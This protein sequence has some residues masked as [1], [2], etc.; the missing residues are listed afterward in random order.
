V[1]AGMIYKKWCVVP[2]ILLLW[3]AIVPAA[4]GIEFEHPR[5]EGFHPLDEEPDAATPLNS[6]K[7][8]ILELKSKL[9]FDQEDIDF[10]KRQITFR[11][12]DSLGF[13]MWEYHFSEL[14]EYLSSRKNFVL[15]KS[16]YNDVANA[17]RSA[18]QKKQQKSLKMQWE[19]P[20]QYPS[21]AQ[22][23]LGNEPPKLVIDG[24]LTI[25]MGFDRSTVKEGNE[26]RD[27][28]S[29]TN[30]FGFDM[31]YQFGI[32]GTVGK[33][34]NVGIRVADQEFVSENN[35]K[36]FKIEYKESTPGE[37]EDEV[38]QEVVAGWTN[39]D[40]PGTELS[41]YSGGKDGL[42][43]IK[44]KSKLGPLT[45]TTIAS[46][47]KGEAQKLNM[48]LKNGGNQSTM[49][50]SDFRRDVF[51]FLDTLY[52]NLYNKNYR[53]SKAKDPTYE[54]PPHVD[55]LEVYIK[56][57]VYQTDQIQDSLVYARASDG[58]MYYF[59]KLIPD[60]HYELYADQGY[61]RFDTT[62]NNNDLVGIYMSAR[63]GEVRKGKRGDTL[64]L[65][66]LKPRTPINSSTED[67]ERFFLMWRNV[68]HLDT[69]MLATFELS[70]WRQ[71]INEDS[72]QYCTDRKG[73]KRLI[74]ALIGLTGEDGKPLTDYDQIYDKK[75]EY[76]IVP[77][78][79]TCS[80]CNEPFNNPDLGA[81]FRDSLI[82]RVSH[83]NSSWHEYDPMYKF[84]SSGS[85]KI[86]SINLGWQVMPNT[87]LV[88]TSGGEVLERDRDYI[89]DYESG[90]VELTSPRALAADNV[91]VTF[92]QEAMFVPESKVF[93]GVRGEM[94]LPFLSEKSFIGASLLF[95]NAG[96]N[97]IPRLEQ[98]P[99]SKLL[100]DL[101]LKADFEPEWMT[102]LINK[103][104]LIKTEQPSSVVLEFEAANSRTNPN[105]NDEA[106]VDDFEDS[107][108]T[109]PLG[110]HHDT[111]SKASPPQYIFSGSDSLTSDTIKI[112]DSLLVYPPA[113]DWFWFQPR[114]SDD[115]FK[116]KVWIPTSTKPRSDD[117]DYD[118]IL[119]LHCTPAPIVEGLRNR[120]KN[121]W[122]GIMTPISQS[123][124]DRSR[125]KYFEFCVNKTESKGK[126]LIIQMGVMNEDISL[127]GGPPN[128]LG[129]RED[130]T[131]AGTQ[132]LKL[133]RGLDRLE[134]N[135]EIYL[136]PNSS[137]DGWD[138]LVY[139]SD[140]LGPEF[141]ND[142]AKDNARVK[143]D[144][145]EYENELNMYWRASRLQF[146]KR[147]SSEDLGYD[148]TVQTSI[149]ESY[150]EFVIDLD[151][152][153]KYIDTSARVY[154]EK[155]WMKY[156]IP[157]HEDSPIRHQFNKPTWTNISMVRLIWT[158]FDTISNYKESS[159]MLSDLQFTGNYWLAQSDTSSTTRAEA[160]TLN[161]QEDENY[162]VVS[163][164][165]G[166]IHHEKIAG[167][168]DYE[169]ESA[170]KI[171]FS[172][173]EPK[174]TALVR[175]LIPF[176]AMDVSQY[177]RMTLLYYGDNEFGNQPNSDNL[178][179]DGEVE[180]IF[181]FGNNDSTYYE[182]HDKIK[183]GWNL[184]NIDLLE[185][186][187]VK[188]DY[189]VHH[190][191]ST[192][193]TSTEPGHY[194][195]FCNRAGIEPSLTKI[196][197]MAL[198]I[199]N[200]KNT[201]VTGTIWVNE[202]KVSGIHKLNGWAARA[203]LKTKWADLLNLDARVSYT[204]GDFRM[205]NESGYSARDSKFDGSISGSMNLDR[206]LPRDLGISIPVG[207]SVSSSVDRPELKKNS[208][209][210]LENDGGLYEMVVDAAKVMSDDKKKEAVDDVSESEKYG[211]KSFRGTVYTNYG[212]SAQSENPLV[213]LTADRITTNFTYSKSVSTTNM[214]PSPSEDQ[215]YKIR[216]EANDY[217]AKLQ[218]DLTPRDNPSWRPF[219][220]T[221]KKWAEQFK[222]YE[223]TLLPSTLKFNL[224][225]VNYGKSIYNE[226]EKNVLRKTYRYDLNHGVNLN[227]SPI[228]PL[229][230]FDYNLSINRDL[231]SRVDSTNSIRDKIDLALSL[232]DEWGKQT[233]LNGEKTRNQQISIALK[234]E[235]ISW[236]TTDANYSS[237][238]TSSMVTR[239][240]D[241]RLYSNASVHPQFTFNSSLQ[242]ESMLEKISDTTKLKSIGRFF[243]R[244]KKG[245]DKIGLRSISF[246]YSSDMN[247]RN[248]YFG[249][250]FF[251]KRDINFWD[252]FK[253]QA[254]FSGR[255][256]GDIISGTMDDESGL[257][258]MK[259]RYNVDD[260][261]L[262]RNDA[263]SADCRYTISTSL[264][265]RAPID[266]TIS[267][268]SLEWND[269]KSLQAKDTSYFDNNRTFPKIQIGA[270]T[271]ALMKIKLIKQYFSS[272]RCNTSYN[273]EKT[274]SWSSVP[275]FSEAV[276]HTLHPL[277]SITGEIA[278]TPITV[279]YSCDK[280]NEHQK[281]G[282]TDTSKSTSETKDEKLD[283]TFSINYEIQKNSRLSELKLFSWTIPVSGKTTVGMKGNV[284]RDLARKMERNTD[285]SENWEKTEYQ[286]SFSL[287]PKIT[288]IFTDNINGEAYYEF[289]KQSRMD[290]ET[291]TTNKFAIIL[292]VRL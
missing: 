76:I 152:V 164:A 277:I 88:K 283:H 230:S 44:I 172:D 83:E 46:Q 235:L 79:D 257:G 49:L 232:D 17:K 78:Y 106:Y 192:I 256:F 102:W 29:S 206:F 124:I 43:G 226:T 183:R 66:T 24:N 21:W 53:K 238:F 41:G 265:F 68:Y 73:N 253:Y 178:M 35:F 209:I 199:R 89:I 243:G 101:N 181:R 288:Y 289:G 182:Y 150:F 54:I 114:A 93:L 165:E 112:A 8:A 103:L 221:N 81:E 198:G 155:G 104:P 167:T 40:M 218:Y 96:T 123:S 33:L 84:N 120:F 241:P 14:S 140:T 10:E 287:S 144:G 162:K 159:L 171:I 177:E 194:R 157:I 15:T 184:A 196:T 26:S 97:D 259:N 292:N 234:P 231:D 203:S 266:L 51:Y 82:Y 242:L 98:E 34:I 91:D 225:D 117:Q 185:L 202:M 52:R 136:I 153:S 56:K 134:D 284:S 105:T 42:F 86:T 37:M 107:R 262:Y 273:F 285:G 261:E 250:D 32:Q 263:R 245:Y 175:K 151:S 220:K 131:L 137:H 254:G 2:A 7:P 118:P 215:I 158:D 276:R 267:P 214:G 189:Q 154:K 249:E 264:N 47:E 72:T 211:R 176:Q 69:N 286:R 271:P 156:R 191:G 59:Y 204:G 67:P 278:K 5:L 195:V 180:F 30:D 160:A 197:W 223:L 36:N 3:C 179:Y 71:R 219:E 213:N 11:R 200:R 122:A 18:D 85:Q 222:K 110:S 188:S 246:T 187:Q 205:M 258:G 201:S 143:E 173:V 239:L 19:L 247:L 58:E 129:D 23:I 291:K 279:N 244:M 147:F 87:E 240:N 75:H 80:T 100:I 4:V 20:V 16:W 212:K 119:R 60:K 27:N 207:G 92:Q 77:P 145:P 121:A 74:S 108:K 12:V 109:Y 161:N 166:R 251:Q 1:A 169:L 61:I 269:H 148:G 227:Y 31:Q 128:R 38:I 208:D 63:N 25:T 94:A 272:M 95:Q 127:N 217:T 39:F 55:T 149:K 65:W 260:E 48:S 99:Y 133:D 70:T 174:D 229:L 113:W 224:A 281:L 268:I 135:N 186:T 168:D 90:T 22:R 216:D 64:S 57:E 170:L 210:R 141:K 9:F 270:N 130:T 190:P 28:Q 125:D 290:T 228:S 252:Y 111:W 115:K 142:P 274:E 62:I 237:S 138:T 13:T 280:S 146:D 248:D 132:D 282:N 139:G 193:D 116:K 45:L 236:L 255:S 275:K 233:I 126:K 6:A 163:T 50:S